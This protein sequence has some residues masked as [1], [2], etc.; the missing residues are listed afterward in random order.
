MDLNRYASTRPFLY[1]LT[2]NANLPHLR[3]MH[4]LIPAATLLRLAGRLDLL[5]TPRRGPV[6]IL[7]EGRTIML[8]DQIP[9][10]KGNIKLPRGFRFEDFVESLNQRLFFWPGGATKPI[11]YGVRHF[12]HYKKENPA[13]LRIELRTLLELNPTV[14]PRFCRY[15]SGSPRCSHGKK[16]PR[17]PR[18][19]LTQSD[20]AGTAGN[21]VEVTFESEMQLPKTTEIASSPRGPWGLLSGC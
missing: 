8:R 13:I 3:E 4:R 11:P 14:A 21:V 19:F 10:Y 1:H 15:N 17:S 6:S 9:L 16:S 20:F 7:V 12:E 5:R 18:T 2:H